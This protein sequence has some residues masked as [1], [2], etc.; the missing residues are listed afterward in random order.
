MPMMVET[1]PPSVEKL[2]YEQAFGEL[3][4]VV[5]ALE[6]EEHSLEEALAL[7]ARGQALLQHCRR[8]LEEAELKV[9]R[10]TDGALQPFAA[11]DEPPEE[12]A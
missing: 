7:Y 10:L 1:A 8:L 2:T 5:T 12:S 9:Q 3:E 11:D 6:Q 4:A